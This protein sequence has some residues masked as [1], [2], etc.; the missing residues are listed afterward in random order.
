MNLEAIVPFAQDVGSNIQVT[1]R[2]DNS[3]ATNGGRLTGVD[4]TP[5]IF[6]LD[7][8]SASRSHG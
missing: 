8:H 4:E 5:G 1:R 2:R 7:T 3:L 6:W